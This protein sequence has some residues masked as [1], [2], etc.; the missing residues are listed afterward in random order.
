V[1]L[2]TRQVGVALLGLTLATV[3]LTIYMAA[4]AHHQMAVVHYAPAAALVAMMVAWPFANGWRPWGR[5]ADRSC[6][7][8]GTQWLPGEGATHCPACGN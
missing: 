5:P 7:S 4:T 1:P 3:G 8:C 6:A 2:S